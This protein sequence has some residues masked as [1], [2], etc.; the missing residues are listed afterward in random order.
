MNR[1]KRI[2][3]DRSTTQRRN[4]TCDSLLISDENNNIVD[5]IFEITFNEHFLT[6]NVR[7]LRNEG[8]KAIILHEIMHAKDVYM[9]LKRANQRFLS[10]TTLGNGDVDPYNGGH[11]DVFQNLITRYGQKLGIDVSNAKDGTSVVSYRNYAKQYHKSIKIAPRHI[12][13]VVVYICPGCGTVDIGYTFKRR[14]NRCGNN[15]TIY[16]NI[17][18]AEV[19]RF[20]KLLNNTIDRNEN[21]YK[22]YKKYLI[23]Y[24]RGPMRRRFYEFLKNEP[25]I[26]QYPELVDAMFRERSGNRVPPSLDRVAKINHGINVITKTVHRF[27]L[28]G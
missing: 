5:A 14:C 16:A 15:D 7:N 20:V 1:L 26:Y 3:F 21:L 6:A 4:A 24:T 12:T 13:D 2:T 22:F 18:P 9:D 11:D 10:T 19:A 25:D 8:I 23:K 28:R 27:N 17:P